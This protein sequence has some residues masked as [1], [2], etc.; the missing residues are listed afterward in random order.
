MPGLLDGI[1]FCAE[2]GCPMIHASGD[3]VCVFE[4][5]DAQVGGQAVRDL[6]PGTPDVPAKLVFADGH[7]MPLLCA[8]CGKGFTSSM[9]TKLWRSSPGNI[10]SRWTTMTRTKH[11]SWCSHL[12]QTTR[13]PARICRF[14]SIAPKSLFVRKN[15]GGAG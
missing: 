7:V 11:S 15:S 5:V 14:T 13:K 3:Y 1:A 10:W 9:R 12:T 6:I 2:H 8:H 4:Y